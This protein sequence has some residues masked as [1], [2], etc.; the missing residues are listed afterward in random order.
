VL[1]AISGG[2][3]S[4]ALLSALSL[5]AP[6]L[7][8]ELAAHGVDHGLR[9][10]APRELELARGVAEGLG[11]AFGV[12]RVLV[13]RGG[14]L[15]ARARRA[16]YEALRDAASAMGCALVATGHTRDDRAETVLIR[17][18]RGA[19]PAGLGVLPAT[20]ES[21]AGGARLVRPLL[22]A[23]RADVLTHLERHGLPHVSD[24]SNDDRRYLRARV[25]HEVLPLLESLSPN[26]RA[27]LAALA[28]ALALGD[29]GPGRP[30]H[31]PVLGSLTLEL[32]G[33]PVRLGRA[34]LDLLRSARRRGRAGVE[35]LL[36]GHGPVRAELTEGGGVRLRRAGPA[37]PAGEV[38][39]APPAPPRGS[40]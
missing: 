21:P 38:R 3:D 29:A 20:A 19:G 40:R 24:P 9:A 18:L 11:V 32:D 30:A 31:D 15:Q 35:L 2:P 26:V 25:R 5:V 33:A 12:T 28:D 37:A 27:H 17:L 14:D 23:T 13:P 10:E 8:L 7:G 22:L 16:R 1:V 34:Q 36:S 39:P 4:V 6:R